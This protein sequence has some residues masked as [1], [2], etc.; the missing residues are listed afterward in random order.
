MLSVRASA[1]LDIFSDFFSVGITLFL[2]LGRNAIKVFGADVTDGL[3]IFS[4]EPDMT[5]IIMTIVVFPFSRN[6]PSGLRASMGWEILFSAYGPSAH[7]SRI[8]FSTCLSQ[9]VRV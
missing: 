9:I 2:D 3:I 4:I 6:G 5:M 7:A 8:I 1:G